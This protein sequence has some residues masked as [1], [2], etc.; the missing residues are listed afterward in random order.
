MGLAA[1]AI[2]L[3]AS[4]AVTSVIVVRA[5]AARVE[6]VTVSSLA[7]TER[8]VRYRFDVAMPLPPSDADDRIAMLEARISPIDL[9]ELADLY[10]QR[11]QLAGD[12]ADFKRAEATAQRSLELLPSPNGAHLTIAKLANLRHDFRLAIEHARTYLETGDSPNAYLT[13][14]TAHLALGELAAACDAADIAVDAR[15]RTGTY[16]MRALVL[17]AQ[18][19]DVEAAYD[20]SRAAAVE[21]FGDLE[22]AARLRALWG[23]FLIRRGEHAGARV[24]LAEALR[25]VPE[26]PLTLAQQAELALRTGNARGA[27]ALFDRAFAGSRE[28]RYLID[29]ARAQDASGD[30]AAA[31]ATRTQ[32]ET[33]VRA[34]LRDHGLG[35][36]LDL[37][38]TL[39]DRGN[40]DD[41]VEAIAL[42]REEVARRASP[43]ALYQLARALAKSGAH[44]SAAHEVRRALATGSRDARIHALAA[45]IERALGN[46]PRASMH[47]HEARRLGGAR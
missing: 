37:V 43:D 45:Q 12:P 41:L 10:L 26:H 36:R 46:A 19:R 32:V 18:G 24:V 15:P 11:G 21:D 31:N 42:A 2:A 3:M 23:R 25:I 44:A 1:C 4:T 6:V 40:G 9:A 5:R 38:E 16:L 27:I 13:L 20:F 28:V 47:E 30:R 22:A 17:E 29:R 14:A 39:V 33:L 8:D 7:P 35:H 34:E